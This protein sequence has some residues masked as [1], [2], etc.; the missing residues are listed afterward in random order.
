LA[1][2]LGRTYDQGPTALLHEGL[3]LQEIGSLLRHRDVDTTALY[4][5]VDV[6]LLREVALPW[7]Q[8]VAPC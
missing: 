2:G 7:P 3:S 4:A 6:G 5:K 1:L 8:E